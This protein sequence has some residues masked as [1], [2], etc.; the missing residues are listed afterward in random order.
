MTRHK[1]T[2]LLDKDNNWIEPYLLKSNLLKSNSK[3]EVTI[4]HNHFEVKNQSIVFILGYTKILNDNFLISNE[5]NLVIHESKLPKGKGFSPVQWQI[6]EGSTFIPVYLIEATSRV[7]SGDIIYKYGFKL[8]G[9]E[10]FNEIRDKQAE[11]TI[12]V[13]SEFLKKYPDFTREKQIGVESYYPRRGVGDGELDIEKSIREQF[14]LL[15]IGNNDGWPSFFYIEGKKYFI[16]IYR[17]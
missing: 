16:K 15:R 11:A 1:V 9:G 4:S 5:L 8:F 2:L 6:L 10:L 17:E 12:F 7:D 14:N 13:V 3:F